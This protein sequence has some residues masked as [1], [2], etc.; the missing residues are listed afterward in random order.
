MGGSGKTGGGKTDFGDGHHHH[1]SEDVQ[2]EV[3]FLGRREDN[4]YLCER[5]AGAFRI[6]RLCP[7]S[8]AGSS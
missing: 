2:D 6:L 7:V 8:A 5:N 3:I 4:M 1:A